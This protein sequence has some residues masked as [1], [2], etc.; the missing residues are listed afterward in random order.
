MHATVQSF[1]DVS[2]T[3]ADESETSRREQAGWASDGK[4]QNWAPVS[5]VKQGIAMIC[6]WRLTNYKTLPRYV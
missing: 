6:G 4:A 2:K 1:A 3:T 5:V